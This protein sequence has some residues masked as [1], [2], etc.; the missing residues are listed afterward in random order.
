M[1][2]AR[3]V[4][5]RG[6]GRIGA[7]AGCQ[8]LREPLMAGVGECTYRFG[9]RVRHGTEP[10]HSDQTLREAKTSRRLQTMPG[11]GPISALAVE[12]SSAGPG[13]RCRIRR[14]FRK[15]RNSLHTERHPQEKVGAQSLS[16]QRV[17]NC[18]LH[19]WNRAELTSAPVASDA[20]TLAQ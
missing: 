20:S 13:L 12:T 17:D 4:A 16:L 6:V 14:R 8:L 19:L 9:G 5:G 3:L 10:M 1:R 18:E 7:A 15:L 11:M 2:A